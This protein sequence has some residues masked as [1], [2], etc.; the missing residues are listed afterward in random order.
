MSRMHSGGKG[1]SGSSRPHTS[2]AP[3]WSASDTAEIEELIVNLAN[4][5]YSTAMILSLIHI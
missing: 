3:A 4:E 2:E 5:G 1:K